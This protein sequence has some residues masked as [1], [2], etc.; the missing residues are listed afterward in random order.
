MRMRECDE[1]RKILYKFIY[2]TSEHIIFNG[3]NINTFY[4]YI[5]Y[6]YIKKIEKMG[7]MF[8]CPG[9]D[10]YLELYRLRLAYT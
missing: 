2:T 9:I 6:T 4:T 3:M 5:L 7:E 1:K 8:L 10:R